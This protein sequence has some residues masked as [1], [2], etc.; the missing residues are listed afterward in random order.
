MYQNIHG[1]ENIVK[2]LL[3]INNIDLFYNYNLIISCQNCNILQLIINKYETIINFNNNE[4][5]KKEF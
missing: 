5:I 1:F 4:Y 3:N 2:I